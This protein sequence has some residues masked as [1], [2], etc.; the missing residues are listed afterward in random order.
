[1]PGPAQ[2]RARAP[3]YAALDLGTNNCRLLIARPH[4]QGFRVLDGFTRI[5]RLGEGLSTTGR[6][7]DAAMERTIEALK[8]CRNKLR[9]HE[10]ARMRLIA[11]EACRAASNG[12]AFI[13][14][15][16]RRARAR[17]RDRRPPDRGRARRHRLRR[18]DR[19]GERRRA[20][21]RYR[22]RLVGTGL[23]R[24]P[25]RPAAPAGPH[26]GLDPLL[27]VAAGGRGVDRRTIRRRRRDARDLR[28]DGRP[29]SPTHLREFRGPR[30]AAPDDR[31]A[32]G[33]PDRHLGHGDDA[34]G[35]ASR[36][37]AL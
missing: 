7:C 1:M 17:T 19:R 18:P 14:R 30:Q 23:A 5:V 8:Q 36:A 22:R 35:A 24:F 20:D 10:P 12:E 29:M 15:V 11:T 2:R 3:V 16:K 34:G 13:A 25:R 31:R 37:R 32:S 21:V 4:E 28:G 27:A 6:L 33:A 26:G 9:E